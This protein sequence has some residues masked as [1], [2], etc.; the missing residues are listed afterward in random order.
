[1]GIISLII[2]VLFLLFTG[3]GSRSGV[4]DPTDITAPSIVTE[5]GV[6]VDKSYF[7]KLEKEFNETVACTGLEGNFWDVS[8]FL[9][10]PPSF[11]CNGDNLKGK[12]CYGEFIR[13]N[14]ILLGTPSVW[15]HEVIHYL[16]YKNTG[17]LDPDHESEL[18]R[19]CS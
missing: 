8:V 7:D 10:S 5:K 3:C 13:P 19:D 6:Y 4:V 16:L 11:P 18:F 12:I 15:K 2:L 14:K 9:M 1:M 17:N